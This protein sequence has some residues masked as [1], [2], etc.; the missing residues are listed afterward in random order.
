MLPE[1]VTILIQKEDRVIEGREYNKLTDAQKLEIMEEN[2]L[3]LRSKVTQLRNIKRFYQD[4]NLNLERQLQNKSGLWYG[5]SQ[6]D[7][8]NP[9]VDDLGF[10]RG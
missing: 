1:N 2:F 8:K 6:P 10:S 3:G 4:R 9:Q 7:L 5:N